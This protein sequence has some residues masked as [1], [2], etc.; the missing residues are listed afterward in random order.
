MHLSNYI[1][2]ERS[3]SRHPCILKWVHKFLGVMVLFSEQF[4]AKKEKRLNTLNFI[5]LP[6]NLLCF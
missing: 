2:N 4:R 5:K 6:G 1:K 3:F